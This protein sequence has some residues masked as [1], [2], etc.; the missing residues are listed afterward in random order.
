[1]PRETLGERWSRS[2]RS[3]GD[4]LPRI[5]PRKGR[6]PARARTRIPR[7][8]LHLRRPLDS[9]EIDAN[10]DRLFFDEECFL[11]AVP[12]AG[13]FQLDTLAPMSAR[14]VIAGSKANGA[15]LADPVISADALAA[16]IRFVQE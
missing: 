3:A 4:S 13:R 15:E 12:G 5:P 16:R 7:L 10:G 2:R 1:M 6:R 8:L 9:D 14:G 11:R